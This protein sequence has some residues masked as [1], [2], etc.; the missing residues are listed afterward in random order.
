MVGPALLIPH[1][2]IALSLGVSRREELRIQV[3]ESGEE[4]G[5]RKHSCDSL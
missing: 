3:E 2:A 5:H 4:V 1:H